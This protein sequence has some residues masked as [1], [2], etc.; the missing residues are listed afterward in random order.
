M[1]DL[2][3]TLLGDR[4]RFRFAAALDECERGRSTA[5]SSAVE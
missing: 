4:R 3:E 5:T 1:L 2:V